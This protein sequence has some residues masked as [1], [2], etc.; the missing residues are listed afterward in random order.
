MRR[1][2]ARRLAA[3]GGRRTG[4]RCV[5][6]GCHLRLT[7]TCAR[8]TD[9]SMDK[10]DVDFGF[11]EPQRPY[12]SGSQRARVWTEQWVADWL[13]CPN[14]AN[15][16]LSQFPANTPVADF[17]CAQCNDQF[18]LKSK[19]G[20]FGSKIANGAYAKKIERLNSANNPNLM[21][22]S[23]DSAS[24]RVKDITVI[25]KHFFAPSIIEERPPLAPT[26]RRAGW[27]G[28]NIAIGRIPQAGRIALVSDGVMVDRHVV[29]E[30]WNAT[31]FLRDQ[32]LEGRGWLLD[33]LNCVEAFGS[34]EFTI[35]QMYNYVPALSLKY[36]KNNNVRA[37]I[38]Q[39]LQVLRDQGIIEFLGHG[40]YV[41]RWRA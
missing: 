1:R 33:V 39:Q 13:Y 25:P 10:D 11:R 6:T 7:I 37:K 17:F 14:C 32:S 8:L 24:A 35:D 16:R 2:Q 18:E 20:T 28:S 38:R 21:L 31:R 3:V 22:M 12:D 15:P 41:R 5:G 30:Q 23:Y 36:P 27:V 4:R 34:A 9:V 19:Q 26:A 40:R 29:V